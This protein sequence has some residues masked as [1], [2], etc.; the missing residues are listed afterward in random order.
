MMAADRL[1]RWTTAGTVI[2]V[3]ATAA[4]HEHAYDLVG[5]MG[6]RVLVELAPG[7]AGP[8]GADQAERHALR[9]MA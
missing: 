7:S 3:A 1:I 6:W 8:A 2:G 5:F 9:F 4:S